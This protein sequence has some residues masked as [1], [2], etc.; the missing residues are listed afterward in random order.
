MIDARLAVII[1]TRGRPSFVGRL[2]ASIARQSRRP[3]QVII[4]DAG[5]P[6]IETVL[7]R[8]AGLNL[9]HVQVAPASLTR[10]KNAGLSALEPEIS[11]VAVLDDDIELE[12]EAL[13]A[14]ARFWDTAPPDIG[15]AAFNL[16]GSRPAR[17]AFTRALWRLFLLDG[18]TPGRLLHS[19]FNAPFGDAARTARIEWLNGGSTV[20]RREV[21]NRYRFDEWF[22][23]NGLCEDVRFSAQVGQAYGLMVV[24][25]ARARHLDGPLSARGQWQLGMDQVRNRLYTAAHMPGVSRAACCWALLGQALM[26]IGAAATSLDAGRL[27]R[28]GGHLAGALRALAPAWIS[29]GA[30]KRVTEAV[31]HRVGAPAAD[32]AEP[33]GEHR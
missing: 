32:V 8:Y 20:W 27:V 31:S 1:P 9:W 7:G 16:V 13:D 22:E 29:A 19:G 10:Q 11:L 30:P 5:S 28:T 3:A 14:M 15:G 25:G 4:A 33:A 24:A 17:S 6:G 26:N 21:F 2:L 12:D 23:R 18:G